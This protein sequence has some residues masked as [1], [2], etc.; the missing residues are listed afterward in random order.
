MSTIYIVGGP[1]KGQQFDLKGEVTYVGRSPENDVI[2]K[3]IYV[4]RRHLKILNRLGRY[5]IQ[6]LESKNGTFVD[7]RLHVVF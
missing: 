4:S 7:G 1:G 2:I 6:D 3:D 5:C